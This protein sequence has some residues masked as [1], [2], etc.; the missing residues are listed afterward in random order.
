MR[1][2][3]FLTTSL[4]FL[5]AM[6]IQTRAADLYPPLPAQGEVVQVAPAPPP[7]PQCQPAVT[8]GLAPWEA[9]AVRMGP[10]VEFPQVAMVAPGYPVDVC[11]QEGN[12]GRVRMCL[13]GV[14]QCSEGWASLSYLVPVR[15]DQ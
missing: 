3:R 7:V 6:T 14:P 15:R 5:W 10:G 1:R 2:D 11:G 9:L 4:A 8:L 12:W 13:V